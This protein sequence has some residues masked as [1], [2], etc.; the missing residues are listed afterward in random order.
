M[1]SIRDP[2]EQTLIL[3][4]V[5]AEAPSHVPAIVA[6]ALQAWLEQETMR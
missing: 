1:A 5:A 2:E 6:M 3:L 4:M